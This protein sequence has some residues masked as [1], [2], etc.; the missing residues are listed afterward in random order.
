MLPYDDFLRAK[1]AIAPQAGIPCTP[2]EVSSILKP[3]QR[4]VVAW[5]VQGGRRAIF[6]QFGMGKTYVQLE[7]IRILHERVGGKFL[8]V[9][10]LG[11]RQEFMTHAA[12]LGMTWQ[13]IRRTEEIQNHQDLYLTNFESVRDGKLDPNSFTGVSLDE[14]AVLRSYGSKTFQEFLRLFPAV[15]YRYVAT[16]TPSPNRTKELI[17]YAGFLG[18]LDTAQALA[19][20][21]DARIYTPG[22][23]KHM[24]DI[25]PGDDVIAAN[26]LP[27]KVLGVFP[28]GEKPIYR[29][30]FS[31]G[32]ST[33]CTA[34]HL[35]LTRTQYERNNERR[36]VQ[37]NGPQAL[38]C[39]TFATVKTTDHIAAT[40]R[41]PS[42]G[43]LNHQI[44]LTQPLYF[45]KQ[46]TEIDPYLFG[47]L[48][49]D[50]H[51]RTTS[52]SF[53][54]QDR[55]IIQSVATQVALDY[56]LQVTKIAE[57]RKDGRPCYDY[58]ISSGKGKGSGGGRGH[59]SNGLLNALRG[60]GLL[61][62][63]A[64]NKYV[65]QEYLYNTPETRLAILQ[66]LMD[67]DGTISGTTGSLHFVTTSPQL[68]ADVQ[69]LVESLGGIA[70]IRQRYPHQGTGTIAGRRVQGKR[71]QYKVSIQFQDE[72]TPFRLSR[73]VERLYKR[74]RYI[75]TRHITSVE[76]V[77][78]K[79]AQCIAIDHPDHLYLTD[80]CIVT[81]NTRFFQRDSTKA[82]NLTLYPHMEQEFWLWIS[83]FCIFAQ[84]PADLCECS[85][86][87]EKEHC[88]GL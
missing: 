16:A 14:A 36:Y 79:Q 15:P 84:S 30:T 58:A 62:A 40:L 67:T 37:R 57:T 45:I 10:P 24:G 28:Q 55:E 83:S 31:D 23:W 25:H 70:T 32:S 47:V 39:G 64:W 80:H 42:T 48:L 20:P 5:A 6:L 50:G 7:I 33:E 77:G 41:C 27:S 61:E 72:I 68:A 34:D 73:K 69:F 11:V 19:Q 26:G 35:W 53:S 52:V 17:H 12:T 76:L 59:R 1:F 4:R 86:H 63:R 43:S 8:I 54:S 88:H 29:V 78:S 22:G 65:P 66:G 49:G 46:S 74:K 38:R 13:F 2:E 60:Y 85:C 82:N 21:L 44:P 75:P 3:F 56:G 18:I 87:T 81:H 9:C 51:L 71:L